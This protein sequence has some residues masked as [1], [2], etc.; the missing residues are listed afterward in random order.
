M[1]DQLV[2]PRAGQSGL[3][4]PIRPLAR[5]AR[6]CAFSWRNVHS[7]GA[8]SEAFRSHSMA[9][10]SVFFRALAVWRDQRRLADGAFELELRAVV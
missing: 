4:R 1:G 5:C 6:G 3:A 10:M 2:L 8:G 7:R 9:G